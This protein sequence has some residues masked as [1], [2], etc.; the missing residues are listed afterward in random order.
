MIDLER[1]EEMMGAATPG[2]WRA[3]ILHNEGEGCGYVVSPG[4][5]NESSEFT[6]PTAADALLSA[7]YST[8]GPS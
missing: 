4:T 8:S 2:R 1:L 6:S 7:A 5:L 3:V